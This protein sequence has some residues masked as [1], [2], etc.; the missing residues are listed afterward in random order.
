VKKIPKIVL[1]GV[2]FI[3]DSMPLQR[4]GAL[5]GIGLGVGDLSIHPGEISRAS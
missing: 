2:R 5:F 1:N 3:H 4:L